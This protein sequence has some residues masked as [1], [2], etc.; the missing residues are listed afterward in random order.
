M[1]ML[2]HF[3]D[4]GDSRLS[5]NPM[6]TFVADTSA[7]FDADREAL[8]VKF[9]KNGEAGLDYSHGQTVNWAK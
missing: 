9:I 6:F 2:S 7:V 5:V 4:K 1:A 8:L 3:S